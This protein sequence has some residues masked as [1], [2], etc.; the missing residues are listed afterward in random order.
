MPQ[1]LTPEQE[2]ARDLAWRTYP[3]D[4]LEIPADSP[5]NRRRYCTSS[6]CG[7]V[8]WDG[9]TSANQ[10]PNAFDVRPD[11]TFTGTSHWRTCLD[12]ERFRQRFR[13]PAPRRRSA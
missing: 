13:K 2:A 10:R 12:R 5:P 7:A 1:Q 6:K 3:N 8:V 9:L 4:A 11:G